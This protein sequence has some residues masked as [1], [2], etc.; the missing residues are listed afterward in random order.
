MGLELYGLVE[1]MDVCAMLLFLF[2]SSTCLLLSDENVFIWVKMNNVMLWI[3]SIM[4]VTID[5]LVSY[6][7]WIDVR[8]NLCFFK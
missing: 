4:V 3:P 8:F 2:C 7:L 5:I 6:I 1:H